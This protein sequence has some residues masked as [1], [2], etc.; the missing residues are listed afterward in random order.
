M[1]DDDDIKQYHGSKYR[2]I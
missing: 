1:E 2:P